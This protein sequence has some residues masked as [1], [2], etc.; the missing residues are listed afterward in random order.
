M[1]NFTP[2]IHKYTSTV[3]DW[4]V[5]VHMVETESGVVLIDG[6]IAASSGNEIR[7][8]IDNKIGK[9]LLGV[10]LTH[11][12]PDHYIGVGNIVKEDVVP[13]YAVQAAIDQAKERDVEESPTIEAAFGDDFPRKKMFPNSVVQDGDKLTF[14]G[15]D[16]QIWHYGACESDSDAVWIISIDG[17]KHVFIGDII[18]NHMHLFMKD[19]HSLNWLKALNRLQSEFDINT[20]FYPSHGEICGTEIIYWDKAYIEMYLGTLKDLLGERDTLT[21]DEKAKLIERVR[22]FFPSDDLLD[23]AQYELD[24]TIKVL[25]KLF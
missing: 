7:D 13:F 19:G 12:H 23:L 22:S 10:L 25:S 20:V 2:V 21:E 9:P 17:N 4:I 24:E 18:Y 14:D 15:L 3:M 16:L 11:G 5:N 6:A 8:I 1:G